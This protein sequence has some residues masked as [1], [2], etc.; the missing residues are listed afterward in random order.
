[1]TAVNVT[2]IRQHVKQQVVTHAVFC[3]IEKT[4]KLQILNFQVQI[5]FSTI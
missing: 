1:M 5:T 4:T 2:E 3:D